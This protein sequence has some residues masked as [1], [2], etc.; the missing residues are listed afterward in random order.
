MAAYE[1]EQRKAL[2]QAM[3]ALEKEAVSGAQAVLWGGG[4]EPRAIGADTAVATGRKGAGLDLWDGTAI[5]VGPDSKA[6]F[7]DCGPS[8]ACR[9]TLEKGLLYVETPKREDG[10]GSRNP[11]RFTIATEAMTLS[12]ESAKVALYA[13]GGS[14]AAVVIE[15]RVRASSSRGGSVIAASGEMIEAKDGELPGM[16]RAADMERLNRWWEGIR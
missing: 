2:G 9:Q 5:R 12:F 11:V 13:S 7:V 14:A 16:P 15:G 10:G 3:A 1:E 4:A 8:R 6:V